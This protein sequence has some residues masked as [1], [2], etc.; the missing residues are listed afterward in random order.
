MWVARD[1]EGRAWIAGSSE[2]QVR[3]TVH[4]VQHVEL[5]V[6]WEPNTTFWD[7]YENTCPC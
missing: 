5:T 3:D 6:E 4:D 2:R 1:R 7:L